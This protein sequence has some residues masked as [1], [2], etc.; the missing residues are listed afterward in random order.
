M[1]LRMR[2]RRL[3]ETTA[4]TRRISLV[5]ADVAEMTARLAAPSSLN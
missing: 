4:V 5:S 2:M 1:N 3:L